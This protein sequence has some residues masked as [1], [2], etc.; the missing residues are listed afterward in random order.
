MEGR[1]LTGIKG[2]TENWDGLERV[3]NKGVHCE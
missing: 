3:G 2:Q 1:Y